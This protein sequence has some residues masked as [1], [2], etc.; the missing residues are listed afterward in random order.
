MATPSTTDPTVVDRVKV[1]CDKYI[2][3]GLKWN[4]TIQ[5]LL[6]KLVDMNCKPPPGFIRCMDCGDKQAGAGFGMIEETILASNKNDTAGTGT[7]TKKAA[8]KPQC[9]QSFS[10]LQNQLKNQQ[11]GVSE[12]KLVP[13]IFICQNHVRSE[14]HA[15]ESIVHELIHAVDMCRTTMDPLQNCVHLACTEI[16]AENLSGECNFAKE[17]TGGR[18]QQFAKHGQQCVKRRAALSV[19]A[20][21]I[22]RDRAHDFV[23]AAFER[24]YKDTY[25]FDRHPSLR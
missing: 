25:P 23:D 7:S 20:N 1:K 24:C 21:P 19:K 3:K 17:L 8:T 12:L 22:C 14:S 15:H 16:R 6:K 11:D 2:D 9:Q 5:F 10:D 13:E 4:P 18:I